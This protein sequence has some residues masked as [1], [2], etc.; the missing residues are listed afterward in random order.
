MSTYL[1]QNK[2]EIN[3]LILVMRLKKL[4]F[5]DFLLFSDLEYQH[6]FLFFPY[7]INKFI[8][9]LLAISAYLDTVFH[10]YHKI[11]SLPNKNYS[12]KLDALFVCF[13]PNDYLHALD[14]LFL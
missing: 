1:C 6:V 5:P 9:L 3:K 7:Y 13:V 14:Y 4:R 12:L 2:S 11:V 10:F 8:C